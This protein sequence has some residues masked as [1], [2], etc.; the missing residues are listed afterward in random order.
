MYGQPP[1]PP[2]APKK[3]S[4]GALI[5]GIVAVAVVALIGVFFALAHKGPSTTGSG[6]STSTST[7]STTTSVA[8]AYSAAVPDCGSDAGKWQASS[9]TTPQCNASSVTITNPVT[10]NFISQLSHTLASS[11]ANYDTSVH[12]ANIANGCAGLGVLG[13]QLKSYVGYVCADGSWVLNNY[14][15]GGTH[16]KIDGGSGVDT[17]GDILLDIK[18]S[19]ATLTFSAN[20]TTLS[21][22]TIQSGYTTTSYVSLNVAGTST[23]SD[24]TADFSNFA[25]SLG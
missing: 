5:G 11:P 15:A 7:S 10:S 1:Y 17:S 16:H 14:D 25:L 6:S 20:G 8:P 9:N 12:I 13:D 19:G 3:S 21:T 2:P 18:I 4:N 23:T 24:C 22:Q